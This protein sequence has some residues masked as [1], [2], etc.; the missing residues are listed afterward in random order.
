MKLESQQVQDIEEAIN[1]CLFS[2]DCIKNQELTKSERKEYEHSIQ[3]Y[4]KCLKSISKEY[5]SISIYEI[6]EN[7]SANK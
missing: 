2:Y 4:S 1:V 5:D 7:L 3:L 6:L